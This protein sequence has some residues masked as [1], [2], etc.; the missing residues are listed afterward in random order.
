MAHQAEQRDGRAS[1]TADRV[2]DV[3]RRHL[4]RINAGLVLSRACA[5]CGVEPAALQPR[6]AQRFLRALRP[7]LGLYLDRTRVDRLI[8]EIETRWHEPASGAAGRPG[9]A[10]SPGPTARPPEA[11]L[12]VPVHTND[13][14]ESARSRTLEAARRAGLRNVDAVKCAT[15]VS[16][17]ARNILQYAGEGVITLQPLPAPPGGLRMVARDRGPGIADVEEI[18]SGRYRSRTGLGLGL[19]GSERL[20]DH[21]EVQTAPATGTEITAEKHG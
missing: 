15:V 12:E 20:V 7:S 9:A 11:P 17:L 2:R 13:D 6:D 19:K 4:S 18:L 21:F 3:L 5:R 1:I 16:E 14:L 10:A 8:H